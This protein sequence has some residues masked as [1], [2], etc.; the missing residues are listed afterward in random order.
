MSSMTSMNHL[1]MSYNNLSGPI[2]AANQFQTF[3]DPSIYE[4]NSQLCGSPLPTDC[5]SAL[6]DE[7]P[8]VQDDVGKDE[9]GL[10]MQWFYIGMAQGF[11]VGFWIVICSTLIMKKSW[12]NAYFSISGLWRKRKNLHGHCSE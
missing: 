12:R 4:R 2:P 11:V 5:S 7:D 9:G 8:G 6:S 10:E 1:N 3:N